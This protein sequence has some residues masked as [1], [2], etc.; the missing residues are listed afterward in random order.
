MPVTEPGGGVKWVG[1]AADI[2]DQ[3]RA[4]A[5]AER[6]S[7]L[8][9]EFLSTLSHELRTPLNAIL[10]WAQ[11]LRAGET[12]E[13]DLDHRAGD[14][15]AERPR[16]AAARRRPAGHEPHHQREDSAEP[17]AGGIGGGD[18]GGGRACRRA[19][20]PSGIRPGGQPRPDGRPDQRRCGAAAAGRVEPAHQRHQVHSGRRKHSVLEL[21]RAED[22][23]EVVVAD[24]GA[25]ISPE[26][27]P[28]VFERFIQ[29]DSST[30]RRF[31]GLGMGLAIVRHL[32]ELHGG[33]VNAQSAGPGR[34]STF[35]LSLP[36][37]AAAADAAAPD[38]AARARTIAPST[39]QRPAESPARAISGAAEE[40][41]ASTPERDTP[42]PADAAP[43]SSR[44][45]GLKVLVVDD[46]PDA[47]EVVRRL[48][49]GYRATVTTASSAA[50][51]LTS[52]DLQPPDILIS[53]IGM[54]GEDGY[55]LIRKVP[56]AAGGPGGERTGG[57]ADGVRAGRRPVAGG[58]EWV[59]G[60]PAQAGGG[61][62][63]DRDDRGPGGEGRGVTEAIRS[64]P[65]A[66]KPA[67]PDLA[68]GPKIRILRTRRQRSSVGR[69]RDS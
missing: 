43:P 2:D 61:L 18:R 9:D 32:V 60:P 30:T 4:R 50:E 49:S 39:P 66:R 1:T 35:T 25:G 14:H 28:Q 40:L 21:R 59:S 41:S 29:A 23:V 46:D 3:K 65:P 16:A 62:S 51:A 37:P 68:N 53:D 13:D 45:D 17:E 33:T 64:L 6:A 15:R 7:K 57:G 42:P 26:F 22:R 36:G 55:A 69:A 47:R 8:K 58:A 19:S 34:G 44:L 52:L 11:L 10:G 67:E 56:L 12:T 38:A 24:T 20:G 27:L 63:A 48:L 5:E 31:G 54:P